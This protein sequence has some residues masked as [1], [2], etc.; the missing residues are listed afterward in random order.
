MAR[1]TFGTQT[2]TGEAPPE[3]HEFTLQG[4]G[5]LSNEPWSETFRCLTKAPASALDDLARSI[6]MNERGEQVWNQVS[7]LRFFFT[8]LHPDDE[9]RFDK[10]VRD[11]DRTVDIGQL[12]DVMLWLSS[13]YGDRPTQ[14]PSSS[15]GGGTS[16]TATAAGVP[17]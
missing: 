16:V 6:G 8:V 3:L 5:Q 2:P 11:K 17:S 7:L 9:E 14:P 10:L 1:R 12:G 15:A 13:E 4:V